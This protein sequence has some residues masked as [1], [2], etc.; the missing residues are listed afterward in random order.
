MM[1]E[2]NFLKFLNDNEKYN[3]LISKFGLNFNNYDDIIIE[4][5]MRV[6][7]SSLIFVL[8]ISLLP[9]PY[10][11][12]L[13]LILISISGFKILELKKLFR[14]LKIL[15]DELPKQKERI[16]KE[17]EEKERRERER[18]ERNKKYSDF[19]DYW[20]Q[21][22]NYKYQKYYRKE[23][24]YDGDY[25]NN[26]NYQESYKKENIVFKYAE[27]WGIDI[28]TISEKDLKY[29]YREL[30]KKYHPD[31]FS[32]SSKEIQDKAKRN[33]QKINMMYQEFKKYRNF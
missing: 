15:S 2:T 31:M 17:K 23:S 7:L 22:D 3:K 9:K 18:Y 5:I 20:G 10:I 33:F 29:K 25:E 30:S 32:T 4:K 8:F 27:V 19:Y 26:G 28:N 21:Y 12:S 6:T 1:S 24:K 14:Y 13:T 16:K 11:F